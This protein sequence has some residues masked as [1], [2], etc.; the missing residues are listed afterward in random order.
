VT[1]NLLHGLVR[2]PPDG[3]VVAAWKG[4]QN[5]EIRTPNL[6]AVTSEPEVADHALVQVPEP[7]RA[8]VEAEA[9]EE[10][11]RDGR[12]SCGLATLQNED[13]QTGPRQVSGADQPVVTGSDENRV[14][15]RAHGR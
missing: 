3:E 10:L 11:F 2:I 12:T 4:C 8:A 14:V 7:V 6:Q 1:S 15:S 13:A 9:R 5:G